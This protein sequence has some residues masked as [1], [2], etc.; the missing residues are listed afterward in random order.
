MLL[1]TLSNNLSAWIIFNICCIALIVWDLGVWHKKPHIPSYKEALGWSF[2]YFICALIF[3]LW[4]AWYESAHW[5]TTFLTGYAIEKSLSIDNV[6]VIALIFQ[7]L[8]IPLPYQHRILFLG[9]MGA[10]VMRGI[11][12]SLGAIFMARYSWIIYVFGAFLIFTGLKMLFQTTSLNLKETW[13]W[14]LLNRFLPISST[15]KGEV[16]IIVENGKKYASPLLVALIFIEM[17]DLIFA[18]DSIPAIF[19]ITHDPFIVYSSNVFA[20]LGLRSLYFL[21]AGSMDQFTYLKFALALI[22]VYVGLKMVHIINIGAL[23]SLL[24]IVG[25]VATSIIASIYVRRNL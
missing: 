12:I 10:L 4:I 7:M 20:L 3:A 14:K 23:Y 5:A 17:S 18:I 22:L 13:L 8:H 19:A 15:L 24:I 6:M 21:I 1:S 16:F 2:G 25:S 9:L 11:L